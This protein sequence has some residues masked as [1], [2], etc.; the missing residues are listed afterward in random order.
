MLSEQWIFTLT[1]NFSG[2]I[3]ISSIIKMPHVQ[4]LVSGETDKQQLCRELI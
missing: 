2:N 1:K 3:M 4:N